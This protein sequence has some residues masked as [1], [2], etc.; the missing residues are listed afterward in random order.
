MG[1]KKISYAITEELWFLAGGE[2][3]SKVSANIVATVDQH[4]SQPCHRLSRWN[5]ARHFSYAVIDA[6]IADSVHQRGHGGGG[7]QLR[8]QFC[9]CLGIEKGVGYIKI[10]SQIRIDMRHCSARCFW[11]PT[12]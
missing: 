5:Q 3:D 6:G 2:L 1:D 12:R 11:V 8:H 4:L 10:K 7:A 9:A